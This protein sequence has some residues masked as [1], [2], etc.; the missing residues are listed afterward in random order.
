MELGKGIGTHSKEAED[1]YHA[2][3]GEEE[4]VAGEFHGWGL[5][6]L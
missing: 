3:A 6:W 2:V 4:V 5:D 1:L